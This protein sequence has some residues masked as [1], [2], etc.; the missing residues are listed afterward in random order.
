M[1]SS[2]LSIF[3]I[4]KTAIVFGFILSVFIFWLNDK[5][6]PSFRLQNERIR[7]TMEQEQT[8]RK[9]KE[10]PVLRNLTIYGAKNRLFYVQRFLT[11]TNTMEGI[12]ILEH[13][14][15]QNLIRKVVARQAVWRD[16][17]W[18]FF[19]S[20]TY[21]YDENGQLTADPLATEEQIMAI[22]ETPAD[23]VNQRQ[24]TD[25]MSLSQMEEYIWRLSM[26]GASTAIRNLK[27]DY[28]QRFT[29]PLMSLIIIMLAIPF[30]LKIRKKAA[31]LSS[32]GISLVLGFLY[33]VLNAVSLALGKAGILFPVAAV[34]L[35]HAVML[36][37]SIYLIGTLP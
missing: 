14:L 18:T 11:A 3:F 4:T 35:S 27:V 33:Y 24:T 15:K 16:N 31:G 25:Y 32:F 30:S 13:D 9:N 8:A 6:A 17:L 5:I 36:I 2:G 19:N 28:Y 20:I 1:R 37:V 21:V 23:F 26:S 29:L 7:E 22:T 34:S 12:V 10:P